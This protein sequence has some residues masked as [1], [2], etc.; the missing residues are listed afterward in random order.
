MKNVPPRA[1]TLKVT[2][3]LNVVYV[4]HPVGKPMPTPSNASIVSF[5]KMLLAKKAAESGLV[6]ELSTDPSTKNP[7]PIGILMVTGVSEKA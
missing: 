3:T 1:K 6:V 2:V 7:Q 4:P 5:T